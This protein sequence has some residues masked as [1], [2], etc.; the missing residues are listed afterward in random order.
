MSLASAIY[1]GVVRHRR[2]SP[3]KHDFS[4]RMYFICVQLD[5][6]ELLCQR[7]WLFGTR[8]YNPIRFSQKDYLP[9]E[10]VALAQRISNKVQQLG[11]DWSSGRIVVMANCR[12]L[13]LYFSPVNFYYL[14]DEQCCRYLL[15][16]VSNTPWLERH[17]YLVDM[18]QQV[19]TDKAF[20]VSPFMPMQMQYHWRISELGERA[21]IHIENH[22]QDKVFYATLA[23]K[24][25][26]FSS[27]ALWATWLRLPW[28]SASIL[29]GIYWQA[30]KIWLKGI[31]YVPHPKR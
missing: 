16:E 14:Y 27:K 18:Q 11:G 20:H 28:M 3:K 26:P 29:L 7:S 23:L 5:E 17:Y 13:G 6:L 8:W 25:Q 22:Q 21:L 30:L 12:C 15:C 4:Y 9:G 10:P 1:Q 31:P 24:R 19:K 2:F